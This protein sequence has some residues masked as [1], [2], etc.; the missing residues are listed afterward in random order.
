VTPYRV[1]GICGTAASVLTTAAGGFTN[2]LLAAAGLVMMFANGY[3][4]FYKERP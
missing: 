2:P 3:A 4:I 1:F